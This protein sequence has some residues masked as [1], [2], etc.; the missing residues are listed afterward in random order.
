MLGASELEVGA[1]LD[2]SQPGCP[3][4][5]DARAELRAR[6]GVADQMASLERAVAG[7][8][9]KLEGV[10]RI[11]A[12][13]ML[14]TRFIVPHLPRFTARHPHIELAFDCSNAIVSL[15]RREADIALRLSRPH[16]EYLIAQRLS[17]IDLG[18]YAAP[19][20][21]DARGMPAH[22]AERLD[23][24]RLLMFSNTPGFARENRWFE[25]RFSHAVVALRASSVS[26][27]Y[28]AAV[29]GLGIALLPCIVA[30][31]DLRLVPIPS[32]RGPE[33]RSIWQVVHRDLQHT[34]R[35]RAVL[36]FFARVLKPQRVIG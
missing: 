30:D 18:L 20:Y 33:P 4:P 9:H 24:H 16:E 3:G 13:E 6:K 28:A 35:I 22:D 26:A 29:A 25:A 11:T 10:V 5:S 19:S 7:E 23:G 14:A 21:I 12:T 15:A 27:V 1:Q 36:D 2:I 8:D 17:A 34:A 32:E 31:A